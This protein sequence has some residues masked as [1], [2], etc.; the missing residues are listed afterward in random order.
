VFKNEGKEN[1]F[2]IP[3]SRPKKLKTV[4]ISWNICVEEGK[5]DFKNE[6]SVAAILFTFF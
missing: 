3:I 6:S 5:I 2:N 4:P 1:Y